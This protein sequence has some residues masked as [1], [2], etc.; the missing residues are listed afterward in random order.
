MAVRERHWRPARNMTLRGVGALCML[1]ALCGIGA[2]R[3][4]AIKFDSLKAGNR[5]YRNITVLGAS[6]TDLYFKHSRGIANVKLKYLE[7]EMQKRFDFD[8]RAAAEAERR[9]LQEDTAYHETV[10]IELSTRAQKAIKATRDAA[11]TSEDSLADPVTNQSLINQPA[12]KLTV[13]Q[14][15]G[16]K[17][18]TEDR[19]LLVF[20]WSTWSIPCRKAIPELNNYHKKFRDKLV[21]VGLSAEPLAE[22][23][24]FSDTKIE[25]PLAIDTKSTL[26]IA[27]NVTSVPMVLLVDAKG[28]VRYQGHPAAL[29]TAKLR[30]LLAAESNE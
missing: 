13:E 20:F 5:T 30:K 29:E 25:F 22:L 11:A 26:A 17:P 9:Q 8:P 21:V 7:P 16:E 28:V 2:V 15:L 4:E 23:S 24:A 12:P 14:W 18:V 3:G 27:A 6:E 10:A 1:L 19:A